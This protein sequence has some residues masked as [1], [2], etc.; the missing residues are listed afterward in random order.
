M[1]EERGPGIRALLFRIPIG[2]GPDPCAAIGTFQ[3]MAPNLTRN[4]TSNPDGN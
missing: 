2:A 4:I 3:P 1:A